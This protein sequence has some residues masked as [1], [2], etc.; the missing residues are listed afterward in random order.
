MLNP[1]FQQLS[2]LEPKLATRHGQS[3][4]VQDWLGCDI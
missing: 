3:K 2:M 4:F 1:M